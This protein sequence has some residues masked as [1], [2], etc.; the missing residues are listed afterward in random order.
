M[1]LGFRKSEMNYSLLDTLPG[2]AQKVCPGMLS[3]FMYWVYR[4]QNVWRMVLAK[5]FK[6]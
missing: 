1:A 4:I 6:E 5:I 2:F 3:V